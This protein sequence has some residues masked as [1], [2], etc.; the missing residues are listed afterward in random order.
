M[1]DELM[2]ILSLVIMCLLVMLVF[3]IIVIVVRNEAI[4]RQVIDFLRQLFI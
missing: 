1:K 3:K 4:A 2:D